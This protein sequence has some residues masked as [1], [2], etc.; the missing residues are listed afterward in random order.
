MV[1]VSYYNL[2]MLFIGIEIMSVS[3]YMLAGIKKNVFASNEAALK[4]FLMGAF[5]TGFLLFGVALIYGASGF[6]FN[7]EAIR[8]WVDWSILMAST[9]CF[10]Q[11]HIINHCWPLL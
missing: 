9:Q 6:A 11:Q 3:L 4:Y 8:N 5:S 10:I 2:T 7:L 1:M